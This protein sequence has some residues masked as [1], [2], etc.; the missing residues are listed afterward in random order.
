MKD[1]ILYLIMGIIIGA[2]IVTGIFMIVGKN[3][4]NNNQPNRE[5][6]RNFDPENMPEGFDINNMPEGGPRRLDGVER[7]N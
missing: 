7:V 1:K 3:T 4:P 5:N 2:I 6:F